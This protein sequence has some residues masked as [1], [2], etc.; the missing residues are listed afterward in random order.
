[1][2]SCVSYVLHTHDVIYDITR[3][4]SRSNLKSAIT[5]SVFIVQCG[6]KYCHNLW[7]KGH[8]CF[9]YDSLNLISYLKTL[10]QIMSNETILTM[11]ISSV[12]S[13]CDFEYCP[14]YSCL[15][16]NVSGSKFLGQ[17]LGNE[18]EY[19]NYI[20]RLHMTKEDLNRY[21][22]RS[23]VQGH[24]HRVIRWLWH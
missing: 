12:T 3:S 4:K 24:N 20:S 21:F 15:R 14:L 10:Q 11:M 5:P 17:F 8:P 13:Q 2:S 23:H 9:T 1:M 18:C 16:D 19:R 6:N 7:L 22:S